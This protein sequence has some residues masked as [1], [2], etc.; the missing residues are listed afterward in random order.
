MSL[1][2]QY[3]REQM[4]LNAPLT[5]A[6]EG[7]HGSRILVTGASG[8]VGFA[9]AKIL[10]QFGVHLLLHSRSENAQIK[11]EVATTASWIHGPITDEFLHLGQFD[12]VFHCATYGQPQKFSNEWRETIRLNVDVL[13]WLLEMTKS[14]GFASTTEIYSG[15]SVPA[16][17]DMVG[18]TTPQHP[19]SAYIEAKRLGESICFHSGKAIS[20]RI[21]LAS[22]PYPRP[23]DSRALYQ[24]IRRA[25]MDKHV[26]LL[27]GQSSIRQY[28]YSLACA[29]RFIITTAYG[30]RAIYNNAGPYIV[31]M[32][33]LA[34]AIAS[35]LNIEFVASGNTDE[36]SGAPAVVCIDGQRPALEF[37]FLRLIDPPFE[38]FIDA[39]IEATHGE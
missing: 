36:I 7:M 14:L 18:T 33:E 27:G 22:G 6:L 31:S 2:G 35:R 15:V 8:I 23:D 5:R 1:H 12:Y 34:R 21:A 11:S 37:P 39:V 25:K 4:E 16:T 26:R 29:L 30:K 3:L 10:G 13:F 32:E 28:Q 24:I 20:N 38:F 9:V 17:E 19:R